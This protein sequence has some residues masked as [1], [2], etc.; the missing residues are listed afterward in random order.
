MGQN[1]RLKRITRAINEIE[2][3]K[4][5]C[6]DC[7]AELSKVDLPLEGIGDNARLPMMYCEICEQYYISWR[8]EDEED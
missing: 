5:A 4:L 1:R 8:E 3:F 2:K 6:K 7:G